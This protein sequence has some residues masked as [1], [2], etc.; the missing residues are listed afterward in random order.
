VERRK[1]NRAVRGFAR[2]RKES[3]LLKWGGLEKGT[4]H[5]EKETVNGRGEGNLSKTEG[6]A[7]GP[8]RKCFYEERAT[9][10]GGKETEKAN[11]K[12]K[13]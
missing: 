1:E 3:T 5:S 13:N 7:S 9:V 12:T 8:L 6:A 11:G 4:T 10:E 2:G